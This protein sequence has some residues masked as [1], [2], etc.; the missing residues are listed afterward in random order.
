MHSVSTKHK[1]TTR[2]ITEAELVSV[3]DASVY[4]LWTLLFLEWKE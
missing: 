4:I 1:I 3:D 2:I